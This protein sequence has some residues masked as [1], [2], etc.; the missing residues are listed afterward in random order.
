MSKKS[1]SNA[2]IPPNDTPLDDLPSTSLTE[3]Q[4]TNLKIDTLRILKTSLSTLSRTGDNTSYAFIHLE[5]QEKEL[6][7]LFGT[8]SQFKHVR[9][10]NLSKNKITEIIGIEFLSFL[11]EAILSEN[12]LTDISSFF[13]HPSPFN[14]LEVL[15]LSGN[16][17]E[18]FK[19]TDFTFLKV[20]N[21]SNNKL[22]KLDCSNLKMLKMLEIRKNKLNSIENLNDCLKLK[23]VYCAENEFENIEIFGNLT[24]LE[25]LHIRDN[26]ITKL[27]S[28][29]TIYGKFTNLKYLNIRSNKIAGFDNLKI[30]T[31]L[32]NIDNLNFLGNPFLEN[33]EG[34]PIESFFDLIVLD[35][36]LEEG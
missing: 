29:E 12:M 22:K 7:G 2:Y 26:K 25:V 19:A 32:T 17:I 24:F 23:K 9:F 10:L 8:I 6:T 3:E 14:N 4:I 21:I 1:V 35:S 31:F 28:N 34:N 16:L 5:A 15:N 11:K 36:F 27:C 13:I 20:L 30:L 33:F 18:E